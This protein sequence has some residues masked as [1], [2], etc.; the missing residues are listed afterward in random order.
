MN[1]IAG[2]RRSWPKVSLR[3]VARSSSTSSIG[4]GFGEFASGS[5]MRD[6]D[7]VGWDDD[8]SARS[9]F[10]AGLVASGG[11]EQEM[12]M[13]LEVGG[14][15]LRL[16]HLGV[17]EQMVRAFR[18]DQL[19]AWRHTDTAFL[20]YIMTGKASS[21]RMR[22]LTFR[23]SQGAEIADT[24]TRVWIQP[25]AAQ[26][27]RAEEESSEPPELTSA[28][29]S[30]SSTSDRSTASLSSK[31]SSA[32]PDAKPLGAAVARSVALR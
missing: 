28:T 5:S 6:E 27:G 22:Q 23:T 17:Q 21:S 20:L 24:C 3:R 2:A 8:D 13:A 26:S 25:G 11:S 16:W 4:E 19:A 18:L 31:C 29:L 1:P 9:R 32:S 15:G 10:V 7:E 14:R 30:W 12:E